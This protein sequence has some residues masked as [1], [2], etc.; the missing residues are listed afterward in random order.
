MLG[1]LE[2][3]SHDNQKSPGVGNHT[4]ASDGF[5]IDDPGLLAIGS[6]V[7]QQGESSQL[8]SCNFKIVH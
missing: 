4:G 2:R 6:S 5:F 3:T 7:S 8:S 1:E